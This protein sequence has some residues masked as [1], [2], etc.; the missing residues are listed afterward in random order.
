MSK[1]MEIERIYDRKRRNAR[2]ELDARTEKIYTQV[3]ALRTL[4]EKRREIIRNTAER[5]IRADTASEML[6][7]LVHEEE[8]L[9]LDNG[10]RE[11]SLQMKY[12]CSECQDTG[13]IG[14][15]E[16]KPCSCRL[17]LEAELDPDI[18]INC[19]ET[20]EN[21][22]TEIYVDDQQ[23]KHTVNAR[24]C[25]EDYADKLPRPDKA[26]LL[27]MG[28]AGLGK[29]FLVN[30]IAFRA[31]S[32]GVPTRKVTAYRFVQD[33]LEAVRERKYANSEIYI[34]IPLLIID[35]LGSEPIIPN[36]TE[37]TLFSVLNERI[38]TGLA[39]V[40]ATNLSV[41]GLME[42][43]GERV[44]SRLTDVRNGVSI[45]LTGDNLRWSCK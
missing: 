18:G 9:L 42:R 10:F 20:F 5:I 7:A 14:F 28:K 32:R 34:R 37:E 16:K 21:F 22:S 6:E 35:D 39:T 33:S 4:S 43:Y 45:L 25:C 31:I 23:R 27:L 11:N 3:P 29:S 17:I 30:A 8:K 44:M 12:E 13:W 26:N 2:A 38:N 24:K 1:N 15:S 19:R 36:I 41:N 40:V